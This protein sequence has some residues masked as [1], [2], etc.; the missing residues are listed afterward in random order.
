MVSLVT[1]HLPVTSGAELTGYSEHYLRRMLRTGK[2]I[3]IK[4]GQV[5]QSDTV[6]GRGTKNNPNKYPRYL[7]NK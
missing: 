7:R 1:N 5:W 3:G 6:I 2:I 4:I